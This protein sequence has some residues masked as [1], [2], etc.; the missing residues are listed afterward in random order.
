MMRTGV[1]ILLAI[2]LPAGLSGGSPIAIQGAGSPPPQTAFRVKLPQSVG[3]AGGT[4]AVPV[5]FTGAE[6]QKTRA[7]NLSVRFPAKSLRFTKVALGGVATSAGLQAAARSRQ[8]GE[9]TVLDI[10]ITMAETP[11]ATFGLPDG[12]L[13]QIIFTVGKGLKPET[14]IPLRLTATAAGTASDAKTI[15]LQADD[16]EII[17]S[18]PSVISCFFYMH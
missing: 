3:P 4:V 18:N 9:D 17:V 12:P 16:S 13:A 2:L 5:Q 15:T 10:A 7:L 11:H 6:A 8:I 1:L 14:V